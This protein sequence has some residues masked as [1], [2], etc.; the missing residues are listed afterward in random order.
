MKL[1]KQKTPWL[2]AEFI[3]WKA[4]KKTNTQ[5][6]FMEVYEKATKEAVSKT[7]E[8]CAEAEFMKI[9]RWKFG[10]QVDET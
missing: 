7:K 1:P 5:A 9:L 10:K 2:P 4:E 3:T 8:P 6:Y